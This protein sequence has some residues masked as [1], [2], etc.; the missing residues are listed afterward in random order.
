MNLL[1][2]RWFDIPK[3]VLTH[4]IQTQLKNDLSKKNYYHYTI[5]AGRRSYKT[6][7]FGKRNLVLQAIANSN[8]KYFAGA[9]VRKQ[10][11][12]IFWKDIKELIPKWYIE[13]ISESE[14]KIIL[15]NKTEINIVGLLEFSSVEGGFANGFIISEWQ[16]CNPDVYNQ[17]IEPMINDVGGWV[18]KEGRPL[19]KNHL[20]EDYIN[21]TEKK[22]GYA[23]Y[24][25]T[26]EEILNEY[27]IDRAKTSLGK[28]D[29]EREYL[30][31]FETGGNPPYYSYSYLNHNT[32]YKLN[33]S[34]PIIVTCDFNATEKPMSWVIG[35]QS[36][37]GTIVSTYWTK[38]FSHTYTNTERMCEIVI[39]YFRDN[40]I[41]P[42]HLIFY[43]DYAGKQI[44][45]NSSRS[46]WQIIETRFSN[47]AKKFEKK[48][49]PCKSIRD[50][51]HAT[52]AQLRNA[53]NEIRQ[54]VNPETCKPLINDWLK[55]E[56]KD[57]DRELKENI[58][59]VG[60]SCRAVD[61]YNDFE[62]PVINK[63]K[64][65]TIKL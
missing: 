15:K 46:D 30:A 29:Y 2:P 42:E 27:Q 53:K 49:K 44:K 13:K 56:W 3:H 20:Y 9:P 10:A 39:D 32:E 1:T 47:H 7:R 28:I 43:G 36:V 40:S 63:F 52:N 35:Q 33:P 62:F 58:N 21:G 14:L 54:F 8:H 48:I 17:S 64:S 24:F 22:K 55:A 18:I 23:S 37:T 45:S 26:S 6:E 41:S 60:H 12:E 50:S 61:Y 11:K 4:D 34:N 59:E 57:N 65:E 51:I 31:S 38:C 5:V 16:K 25:W 19:G